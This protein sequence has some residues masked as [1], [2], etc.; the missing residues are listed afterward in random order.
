MSTSTKKKTPPK[1][2]GEIGKEKNYKTLPVF[3][4]T[5]VFYLSSSTYAQKIHRPLTYQMLLCCRLLL[6]T[7]RSRKSLLD[8]LV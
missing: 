4:V 1:M 5:R 3:I 7:D 8:H 6:V 2:G